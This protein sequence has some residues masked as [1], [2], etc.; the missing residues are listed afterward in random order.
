MFLVTPSYRVMKPSHA[1]D[2]APN[3]LGVAADKLSCVEQH[4]PIPAELS[5]LSL[6]GYRR[7]FSETRPLR[8]VSLA[9]RNASNVSL[10]S[11]E[12]RQMPLK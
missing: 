6:S 10:R 9:L 1:P 2:R 5:H 4:P 3:A 8:A 12:M 11:C 7:R